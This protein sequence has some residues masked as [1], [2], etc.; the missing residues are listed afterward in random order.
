MKR[1]LFGTLLLAALLVGCA[2]PSSPGDPIDEPITDKSDPPI[3]DNGSFTLVTGKG[4]MV[5]TA[6]GEELPATEGRTFECR[7]DQVGDELV[8]A[9]VMGA[10]GDRV[11]IR[12]SSSQAC[13]YDL[14]YRS[15]NGDEHV[16]SGEDA[17]G[18][19]FTRALKTTSGVT[20]V[21]VNAIQ[22]H[23]QEGTMHQIDAVTIHCASR[24]N[25]SWSALQPVVSP[26]GA[27]A[28]WIRTLE[29]ETSQ[30]DHFRLTFAHD[31]SFQFMNLTDAGRPEGDGLYEVVFG[32]AGD[33]F[34]IDDP[35]LLSKTQNPVAGG[36]FQ[37]WKPTAQEKVD[38]AEFM[39]M[40]DGPCPDGCPVEEEP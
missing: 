5:S 10:A 19:L 9:H 35:A 29:P 11:V 39:S 28:A 2:E 22:H 4:E 31:F 7:P 40:D 37:E 30:V 6:P 23:P 34:D 13:Y 21:C 38:Y 17:S 24:V 3:I 20:V 36:E 26:D 18:Y 32:V 33:T 12:P 1:N 15:G 25:G 8:M 27:W 14:V 16:L